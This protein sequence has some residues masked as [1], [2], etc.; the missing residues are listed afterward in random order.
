MIN[1][2]DKQGVYEEYSVLF[3]EVIEIINNIAS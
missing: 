3:D 1:Y 2:V